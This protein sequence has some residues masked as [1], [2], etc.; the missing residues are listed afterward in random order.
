M[1]TTGAAILLFLIVFFGMN[2]LESRGQVLESE[3]YPELRYYPLRGEVYYVDYIQIKGTPFLNGEEWM[4]GE[5]ILMDG[6]K[7]DNVSIKL[8]VYAHRVLVYQEYLRRIVSISKNDIREF[9]VGDK[10]PLRHFIFFDQT[11]TKAKVT[12]GVYFEV[13]SE[14]RISFY[15]LYFKD[16]LPLRTPEMPLLDEFLDEEA[17][18]IRDGETIRYI[19]MN[20]NSL[21]KMYPEYKSEIKQFIRRKNLRLREENDFSLTVSYLGSVLELIQQNK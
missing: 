16:V 1:T 13:L 8:D 11:A 3:R 6:E 2:S 12:D 20:K 5:L 10:E 4:R 18:Y 9:Y 19:R 7:I 17:Y 15:K 21:I 14:G